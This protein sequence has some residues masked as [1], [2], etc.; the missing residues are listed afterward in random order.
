MGEATATPPLS[1]VSFL[2]PSPPFGNKP[3]EFFLKSE[4]SNPVEKSRL[5]LF[6]TGLLPKLVPGVMMALWWKHVGWG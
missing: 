5:G 6:L 2:S 3:S 1:T 4:R